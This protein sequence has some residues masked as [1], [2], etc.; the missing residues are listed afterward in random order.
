MKG[1]ILSSWLPLFA[2]AAL[3]FYLSSVP[4]LQTQLGIWDLILRKLAHMTEYAVLFL[5][6]R[7]AFATFP[8]LQGKKLTLAA[9]I[10][11]VLYAAS[12]EWHQSF[13]PGR[14]PSVIDVG[15]DSTGVLIGWL[16]LRFWGRSKAGSAL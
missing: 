10:F 8:S 12:D 3:I 4:H 6:A 9:A 1:R 2:W 7:R 5:L 13:V 16:V 15:I 14:G 11:A